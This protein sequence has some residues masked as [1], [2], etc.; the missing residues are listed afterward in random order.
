M[1]GFGVVGSFGQSQ[2]I[3]SRRCHDEKASGYLYSDVECRDFCI[4]DLFREEIPKWTP[5]QRFLQPAIAI[6]QNIERDPYIQQHKRFFPWIQYSY[7]ANPLDSSS[8]PSLS[9]LTA[10]GSSADRITGPCCC[11]CCCLCRLYMDTELPPES[12]DADSSG[13]LQGAFRVRPDPCSTSWTWYARG[14]VSFWGHDR[15]CMPLR[16]LLNLERM[17][18]GRKGMRRRILRKRGCRTGRQPQVMARLTSMV[19]WVLN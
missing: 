6:H 5:R 2:C 11:C 15:C 12:H 13:S 17:Y 16:P 14:P 8:I 3:H 1:V 10:T 9:G 7:M 19:L 4:S 18:E